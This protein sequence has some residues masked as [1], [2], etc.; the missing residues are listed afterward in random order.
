MKAFITDYT[1]VCLMCNKPVVQTHHLL[2]GKDRKHADEDGLVIPLCFEHHR[3][4]HDKA[5]GEKVSK[6]IGQLFWEL[7]YVADKE[8]IKDARTHFRNRYNKSHI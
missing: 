2:M 3:M 6:I 8:Q 1:K 7:N 4:L 5:E